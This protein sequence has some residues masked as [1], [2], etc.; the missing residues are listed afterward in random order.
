MT[1]HKALWV[2]ASSDSMTSDGICHA[3]LQDPRESFEQGVGGDKDFMT[4]TTNNDGA[5][6]S[7]AIPLGVPRYNDTN[8]GRSYDNETL[9]DMYMLMMGSAE[10]RLELYEEVLEQYPLIKS[11][12]LE[13]RAIAASESVTDWVFG[14]TRHWEASRHAE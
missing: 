12:D 1:Q 9:E 2:R 13:T 3:L 14:S 7:S 8:Y 6:I 11:E 4:G 10:N 5:F